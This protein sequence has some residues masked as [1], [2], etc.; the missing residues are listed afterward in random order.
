MPAWRQR[1]RCCGAQPLHGCI[2]LHLHGMLTFSRHLRRSS[3]LSGG[4]AQL[5]SAVVSL[6]LPAAN[7]SAHGRFKLP[8]SASLG[9]RWEHPRG[10]QHAAPRSYA[11]AKTA[12]ATSEEGGQAGAPGFARRPSLPYGRGPPVWLEVGCIDRARPLAA[13]RGVRRRYDGGSSHR[14]GE[15]PPCDAQTREERSVSAVPGVVWLDMRQG[16]SCGGD[17][18]KRFDPQGPVAQALPFAD[19]ASRL[20]Q[21]V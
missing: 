9:L 4:F 13:R 12:E 18:V 1:V 8:V 15:V 14:E 20:T 21:S 16:D 10:T 11:T 7:A 5:F 2:H 6:Q 19:L 3:F 17:A